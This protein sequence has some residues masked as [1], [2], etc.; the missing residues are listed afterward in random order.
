MRISKYSMTTAMVVF[1]I[2]QGSAAASERFEC[3]MDPAQLVRLAAINSGVISDILVQR[4]DKVEAGQP[5]AQMNASLERATISILEGRVGSTAQIEAQEA[6]LSFTKAQL[7]RM[8]RLVDQS[9]QSAV[10]LEEIQY[11]YDIAQAQLA[12]AQN[13][14]ATLLAELQRAQ[15]AY[16]NTIIRS[17]VDGQVLN[18]SLSAGE[19]AGQDRHIMVIARL[20][21]LHIEAFLPIHLYSEVFEGMNVTIYPD[22]PLGGSHPATISVIDNVFDTASRTFGIR[23]ELENPNSV[24]PGGYRCK[25]E[26]DGLG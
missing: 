17:P 24:I 9:A 16:E 2:A 20:D 13:D 25:L 3:I 10:R 4:G 19:H 6:R 12:Q 22:E 15:I 21:P 5:V 11:E 18:V 7:E 23:V 1:C 8:Q 14:R 26:L